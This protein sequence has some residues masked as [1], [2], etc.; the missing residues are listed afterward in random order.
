[1]T[2]A[3]TIGEVP[4]Q[5]IYT[6]IEKVFKVYLDT[7]FDSETIDKILHAGFSRVP[8]ALS[9]SNPII[10]GILLTKTILA[11]QQSGSTFAELYKNG[12]IQLKA[13]VFLT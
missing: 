5:N 2:G 7:K 1:M 10:V 9:Q 12:E 4:I 11:V 8:V 3:M 6:P 13:P